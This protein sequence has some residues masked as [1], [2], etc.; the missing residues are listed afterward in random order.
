MTD[1]EIVEQFS[2][3]EI[4]AYVLATLVG[5]L[6][7]EGREALRTFVDQMITRGVDMGPLI[8]ELTA[9]LSEAMHERDAL[10]AENKRLES[11]IAFEQGYVDEE[12]GDEEVVPPAAD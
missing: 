5:R 9:V 3:T 8:E 12:G 6:R 1:D 4:K 10:L 7:L 2:L 11:A